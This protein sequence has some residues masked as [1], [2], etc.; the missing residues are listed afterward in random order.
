MNRR[1]VLRRAALLGALLSLFFQPASITLATWASRKP[2]TP[3]R[4]FRML[5]LG[6]SV[7]WGQGLAEEHKFSYQVAQWICARRNGGT[8]ADK[9]DVQLHV[10]AHSGA[11]VAKPVSKHDQDKDNQFILEPTPLRY[12]GE[13]N[14][15]Y[16]TVWTEIELARRFYAKSTIPLEEVDLILINGGIND[17]NAARLFA[18]ILGGLLD[19]IVGGKVAK[20]AKKYC[21]LGM[22]EV[23]RKVAGT[24]PH[25]RIVVAGYFPLISNSTPQNTLAEAIG[26]LRA[27]HK[28]KP[29]EPGKEPPAEAPDEPKKIE[30]D[31]LTKLAQR[32]T[33]WVTASDKSL[34]AAVDCLNSNLPPLPVSNGAGPPPP[35]ASMR[36]LFVPVSFIADNAYGAPHSFL[37]QLVR[38]DPGTVIECMDKNPLSNA[39]VA[40]ELQMQRPCQC[41]DAHRRNNI[42][43]VRAGLFHPN[44]QG[45]QAYSTEITKELDKIW[46]FTGWASN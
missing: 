2:V 7:M 19:P 25:A 16:P 42:I 35:Q 37:W 13:V 21:E 20:F 40:D 46:S 10:E 30:G 33:D 38:K 34:K 27:A 17:M 11:F 41:N 8:C 26:L 14:N 36:A 39:I 23:L 4:P 6:D 31:R 15:P 45:A 18:P 29:D 5:V 22:E 24:F 3:K 9:E 44:I 43:C 1:Q 28:E 12:P 32:S